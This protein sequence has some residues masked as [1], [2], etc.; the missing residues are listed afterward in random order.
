MP[1]K[2]THS[3]Q[4]IDVLSDKEC[5]VVVSGS[6]ANDVDEC[7]VRVIRKNNDDAIEDEVALSGAPPQNFA[8]EL[9]R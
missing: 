2:Q 4:I 7:H 5:V 8:G 3:S 6:D 9:V 1:K